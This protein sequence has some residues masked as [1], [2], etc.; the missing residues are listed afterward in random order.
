M[1]TV[2]EAL[3]ALAS[4]RSDPRWA[5]GA[6]ALHRHIDEIAPGT[7]ARFRR[8]LGDTVDELPS[9]LLVKWIEHPPTPP[10]GSG[11][12]Y[13]ARSLR[14][15]AIDAIR[16]ADAHPEDPAD[17]LESVAIDDAA[18]PT[19]EEDLE[20]RWQALRAQMDEVA[21][22]AGSLCAHMD[23]SWAEL[24]AVRIEPSESFD[25][26]VRRRLQESGVEDGEEGYD[27]ARIRK[28]NQLY[29]RHGRAREAWLRTAHH[30]L[31]DGTL[32]AASHAAL[33]RVHD[34]K[35]M[36]KRQTRRRRTSS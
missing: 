15:L 25:A 26:L 14:N 12:S 10:S 2:E 24:V 32:S 8:S 7:L 6:E 28:R 18:A 22:R 30:M 34:A 31:E 29:T 19:D 3:A 23:V 35:L 1:M 5:E 21:R 27:A 13:L 16:R 9:V 17:E 36:G 4:E 20:L 11:R 33:V